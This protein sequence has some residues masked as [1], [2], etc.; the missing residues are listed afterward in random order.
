MK[1]VRLA[2][3]IGVVVSASVL[4]AP[5]NKT[6]VSGKAEWVLHADMEAL[7]KT[8][9][10]QLIRA[11]LAEQ[12]IEQKLADFKTFFSFHPLDDIRNI[13]VYGQGKEPTKGIVLVQGNF[14]QSK[15]DA[16]VRMNPTFQSSD[17]GK[18]AI[19]SWIDEK[20]HAGQRIFG[21]WHGTDRLLL[22]QGEDTV[23]TALDVLDGKADTAVGKTLVGEIPKG[24]FLTIFAEKI[25]EIVKG[26]QNAA[27]LQQAERLNLSAGE[28]DGRSFITGAL[29]AKSAMESTNIAQAMQGML[30]FAKLATQE[31]MPRLNELAN[32]IKVVAENESVGLH[33]E[34]D[35][36]DLMS[37][38]KQVSDLKIQLD[39]AQQKVSKALR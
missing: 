15:L 37:I 27:V 20:N 33:F 25:S 10:A 4:A 14:D 19:D 26:D 30:A 18:Y 36:A 34:W 3:L 24:A 28:K 12:G 17:Y 16:M 11:E 9:L 7:L 21:V 35:S 38:L 1:T 5:L 31:K 2:I 22:S 13:T 39:A 8:K 32:A 29:V 6:T 23:K